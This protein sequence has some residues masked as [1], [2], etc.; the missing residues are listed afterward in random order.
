MTPSIMVFSIIAIAYL[1]PGCTTRIPGPSSAP[2]ET[3]PRILYQNDEY[4]W[5]DPTAFGPVPAHLQS[6][7]DAY[8]QRNGYASA[9]G[10]HPRAL[11]QNGR[12]FEGG[13]YYCEGRRSSANAN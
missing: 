6:T 5:D 7:G 12:T 3:P 13:G 1:T 8:C 4:S 9:T 11:D 2:S 10:Y